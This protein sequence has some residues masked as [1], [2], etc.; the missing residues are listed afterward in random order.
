MNIRKEIERYSGLNGYHISEYIESS[1]LCGNN[2]FKLLSD[3]DEGGAYVR[4][5][6]CN[7]EQ[8]IE[9]S[10]KYIEEEV[11]NICNCDNENLNIG[12][13]KALHE[14]STEAK[15]VYADK[16]TWLIIG[17]LTENL[18]ASGVLS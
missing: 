12:I 15:W 14:N 7:A 11:S 8:D 13:G 10:R 16:T 3:D 18:S 6:S 9:E 4:C 1:C 2:D 17:T 5:S